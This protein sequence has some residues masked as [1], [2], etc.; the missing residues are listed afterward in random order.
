MSDEQFVLTSPRNY[1]LERRNSRTDLAMAMVRL[2]EA[3]LAPSP[4]LIMTAQFLILMGLPQR[5]FAKRSLTRSSRLGSGE[6]VDITFTA[7]KE[8]IPLPFGADINVLHFLIHKAILQN[9]PFVS[10]ETA[11]EYLDFAG[12]KK[13]GKTLK[14]LRERYERLAGMAVLI[15]RSDEKSDLDHVIPI[16][17]T[18]HLP[19]S[20]KKSAPAKSRTELLFGAATEGNTGIEKLPYGF[21]FSERYFNDFV[22]HNVP[23]LKVLIT[24]FSDRPQ[25]QQYVGFLGWRSWS[26]ESQ[27]LIP[28][29]LLKEQLWNADSNVW[30]IRSQF[31]EVIEALRIAWPELQ[32]EARPKGLWIAPP[33]GKV[34]LI[35]GYPENRR[36]DLIQ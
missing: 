10:W 16:I 2:R 17:E 6:W 26:A 31:A 18:S 35:P 1:S 27:S 13:G 9:S 11:Q 15:K 19:K 30:R 22:A 5:P 36:L 12:L 14:E 23:M 7:F 34:H 4:E 21:Q 33:L 28:W 32:A 25:L 3:R 24:L 29:T 8:G 20:I